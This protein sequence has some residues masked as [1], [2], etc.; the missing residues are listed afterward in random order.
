MAEKILES[1]LVIS[2]QD[3]TAGAIDKV[4]KNLDGAIKAV[5]Q[6]RK[7]NEKFADL[8]GKMNAAQKAV[9]GAARA[10][11]ASAQPSKEM[12]ANYTRAR[13]AVSQANRAF[14]QQKSIVLGA[15][16]EIEG[17][18]IAVGHLAA[19]QERLRR[20]SDGANK[21]LERQRALE[22]RRAGRREAIGTAA[23]AGGLIA[24]YE[25]RKLA[26][27]TIETYRDFDKNRRALM[28]FGG[29]TEQ[30]ADPLVRQAIH[31]GATSK[32][33]DI[34][35]L[36]AQKDI[37]SRGLS[38]DATREVVQTAVGPGQ[39]FGISLP[40]AAKLLEGA[41][42]GLG[43]DTS[44]AAAAKAGAGRSADL[45]V[46]GAK[47]TGM[48]SDDIRELYKF[49]GNAARMGGLSEET[50]LAFGGLGK[51]ANIGGDEMGV[52]WRA[53]V[54]RLLSPTQKG[55]EALAASGI[56]YSQ[57]QRM[58]ASLS[59]D[60][61][62]SSIAQQYGV[63]LD[64]GARGALQR[65]FSDPAVF[66]NAGA[67]NTAVVDALRG[68]SGIKGAQDLAKVAKSSERFR[69]FSVEGVNTNALLAAIMKAIHGGNLAVAN[70]YFGE[71]QGGRMATALRD[72]DLFN[73]VVEKLEHTQEGFAT[74][75][76][77]KMMGGFDGAMSRFE[78][79]VKN[80]ETAIGRAWDKGPNG[81]A[82]TGAFNIAGQMIQHYAELDDGVIKVTT[83]LGVLAAGATAGATAL[84][85]LAKLGGV[86]T[87]INAL[88]PWKALPWLAGTGW[89]LPLAAVGLG[90][91]A[92]HEMTADY[93]GLT[94]RERLAR[95]GVGSV[96]DTRR[97]A[98]NEERERLGIDNKIE[99]TVK[100]EAADGLKGSASVTGTTGS[101]GKSMTEV[102]GD[103]FAWHP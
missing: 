24:A 84:M 26:A 88:T 69:Q 6:F 35:W 91:E 101:T 72:E 79:S 46:R 61:F 23:G 50:L 94:G 99:V 37:L 21:A 27:A 8:R 1:S 41:V 80:L 83:G 57:F 102:R 59:V 47:L 45:M 42:F 32:Y 92:L 11:S 62:A 19:E 70:A 39:A 16:H 86:A 54:A 51:K 74:E 97:A 18:G 76:S 28:A 66:G 17:M 12:I 33:N 20:S 87:S 81:G 64:G 44:T 36:E 63:K 77:N 34:Q 78:G 10:M 93:A 43:K 3:K 96:L 40:E 100:V 98:F 53:L 2:A 89:G 14:Q 5:D 30:Q 25:G 38:V 95:R 90:G 22:G 58:P 49:G 29:L 71:K 15:K 48:S 56:N 82:L 31:G 60:N 85:W 7:A 67:F 13:A 9:E 4:I 68:Q 75:I 103:P 65:A 52:A 55:K 73:Q